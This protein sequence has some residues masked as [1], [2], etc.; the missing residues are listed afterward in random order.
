MQSGLCSPETRV[1]ISSVVTSGSCRDLWDCVL[2][3]GLG[4]VCLNPHLQKLGQNHS[5]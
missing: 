1:L 5:H 4:C 2:L 3:W